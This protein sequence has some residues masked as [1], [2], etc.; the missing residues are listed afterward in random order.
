MARLVGVGKIADQESLTEYGL[1]QMNYRRRIRR[2][3]HNPSLWGVEGVTP[4]EVIQ[5]LKEHGISISRQTLLNWEKQ[6]LIPEAERGSYGQGGGKWT[7]Y[8]DE[9]LP[10]ALTLC[11]LKDVYRLRHTEIAEARSACHREDY[12]ASHA[13][14]WAAT[15]RRIDKEGYSQARQTLSPFI[16]RLSVE[17]AAI[18]KEYLEG[19]D[20]DKLVTALSAVLHFLRSDLAWAMWEKYE[21][22]AI[23]KDTPFSEAL[24]MM[25]KLR[26]ELQE[27]ELSIL[28][29]SLIGLQPK[30]LGWELE[31]K[32]QEGVITQDMSMTDMLKALG[33][34]E[35]DKE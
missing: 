29:A 4:D 18:T 34:E 3:I 31:R 14:T 13:C 6:G 28:F 21:E 32:F 27:E 5:A 8:P 19:E 22:G 15:I 11:F 24:M 7:D 10:E 16:S 26:P 12:L 35:K 25:G 1:C 23:P 33:S 20:L 17:L 30:G 9:T 2:P